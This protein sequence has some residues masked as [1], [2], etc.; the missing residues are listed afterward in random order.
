MENT[1]ERCINPVCNK[2]LNPKS[3]ITVTL[4]NGEKCCGPA[5]ARAVTR[6]KEAIHTT[7]ATDT[8]LCS[9]DL[10]AGW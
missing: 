3:E 7:V 9:S 2:V 5:C 4:Q 6:R 1:Q 10:C 8:I